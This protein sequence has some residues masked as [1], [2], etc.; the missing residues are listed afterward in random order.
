MWRWL[1]IE[2]WTFKYLNFAVRYPNHLTSGAY[3]LIFVGVVCWFCNKKINVCNEM[4]VFFL[5]SAC[6]QAEVTVYFPS[7]S[8]VSVCA[9]GKKCRIL[10]RCSWL[11]FVSSLFPFCGH[12]HSI[13]TWLEK[14]ISV[15]RWQRTRDLPLDTTTIFA[16]FCVCAYAWVLC[17][18]MIRTR[19]SIYNSFYLHR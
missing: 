7:T 15:Q 16:R 18:A 10:N 12:G 5:S 3:L 17:K 19:L 8:F 14:L 4:K 13:I 2:R 9:S 1:N 11:P 6:F